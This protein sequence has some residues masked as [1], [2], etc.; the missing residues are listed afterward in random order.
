MKQATVKI[1]TSKKVFDKIMQKMPW[2]AYANFA[3]F[4]NEAVRLRA[5]ELLRIANM[6]SAKT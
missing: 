2:L 1:E 3:E 5:I 6:E 4:V